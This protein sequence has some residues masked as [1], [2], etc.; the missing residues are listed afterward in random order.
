MKKRGRVRI[1]WCFCG[2]SH[3]ELC[4]RVDGAKSLHQKRAEEAIHFL[5]LADR[6]RLLAFLVWVSMC[7]CRRVWATGRPEQ[8]GA[9]NGKPLTSWLSYE[10]ERSATRYL[11]KMLEFALSK[12]LWLC[13]SLSPQYSRPRRPA[14]QHPTSKIL[15]YST[16][17]QLQFPAK[18]QDGIVILQNG[19]VELRNV[20]KSAGWARTFLNGTCAKSALKDYPTLSGSKNISPTFAISVY[21]LQQHLFYDWYGID[22]NYITWK[23]I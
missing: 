16:H 4:V 2:R 6:A 14:A 17:S 9:K 13:S 7:V 3:R 8:N 12:Y 15:D 19:F 23:Y 18:N 11:S 20:R 22:I 5:F 1:I 21:S 10:T